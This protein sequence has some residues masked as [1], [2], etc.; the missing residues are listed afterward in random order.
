MF[1]RPQPVGELSGG[2]QQK[3][4]VASRLVAE[5]PVLVVHEPTRGVDVGARANLHAM[6]RD[7]ADAGTAVILITTDVE[8]VVDVSDRVVVIREGAVVG[9]LT[10]TELTQAAVIALATKARR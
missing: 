7:R 5:P 2:N 6:L 4:Q 3:V 9:E 1:K 8:E 10:G